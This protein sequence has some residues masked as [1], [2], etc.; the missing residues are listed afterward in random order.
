MLGEGKEITQGHTA[1]KSP[2]QESGPYNLTREAFVIA[3]G[4]ILPLV[5]GKGVWVGKGRRGQDSSG[6]MGR[7]KKEENQRIQKASFPSF[8]YCCPFPNNLVLNPFAGREA[9][10]CSGENGESRIRTQG[11]QEEGTIAR[12]RGGAAQCKNLGEK[13]TQKRERLVE[14]LGNWLPTG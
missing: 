1:C 4:S 14:E 9:G 2:H 10:I 13:G 5:L 3:Q 11:R 12:G 7:R 6:W 8:S